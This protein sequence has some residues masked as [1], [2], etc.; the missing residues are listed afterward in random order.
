MLGRLFQ[1]LEQAVEGL[2]RQHV[3]LVD[4]VD[5]VAGGVR[6]VV[7]AVDQVADVVDASM[8]RRVHLDHVEMPALQDGA[9]M[10]ALL[11]HVERGALDAWR[12]VIERAGDQPRRG[13]LAHPAHTGQHI[14][15]R[16]TA[17]GE[18][19]AQCPHHGL[20]PDQLAEQLRPVFSRQRDVTHAN[21]LG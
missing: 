19:V 18:G 17:R 10:H 7:G 9:A 16:D 8:G 20:L 11:S 15:L 2:L 1:R 14:G 21:G 12:F 4:D 6:L 5:L 3:H 13:G